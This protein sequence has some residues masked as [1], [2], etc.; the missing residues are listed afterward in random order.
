MATFSVRFLGCKVSHTDAQRSASG[1]S[2]T[3]TPR[4]GEARA[5][6]RSSTPAASRTRRCA[7]RARPPRARRARTRASTSPAAARTS[8]ATRSRACRDERRRRR[9]AERG[10]AG[11][12][13]RRR[14]RDRLRPGRRAA[15][16]RARVR[17]GA[18]RLQLL[19]D[20]CVDPARARRLAQPRRGRRARR[21]PPPRRAGAPRGRAHRDQPRLLPR[22]RRRLRLPRLV[23]EAGAT[24]G[25]A[26]LRL[27]SIEVNHVDDELVAAL[28][29]TPTVSAHLHVPLQSGD[30]G[31][32]RAMGRRYTLRHVP[33]PAR[34]ARRL[35]PDDRRDRRLPRR[36]RAPPS[37]ARS[38]SSRRPG[39]RRCTSSRTRRGPAR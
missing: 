26:R 16:P 12:R 34:A 39:S 14:R 6:S 28:R 7:S 18:G 24:P 4:R 19:C 30:D 8:P 33:A 25:L 13:R 5:T 21:D 29:E 17:Q 27:S 37:S 1:C 20:F 10:D 31:V 22:P 23:R 35:Q 32:L 11:V 36:G 3:A 9:A 38:T 2:P 15:R